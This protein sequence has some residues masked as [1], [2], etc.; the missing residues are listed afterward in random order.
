MPEQTMKI[1]YIGRKA[2]LNVCFPWMKKPV[3]MVP[4]N[5]ED[6]AIDDGLRL[7]NDFPETFQE[8]KE[9]PLEAF[10]RS[11]NQQT[12]DS[13][14][15]QIDVNEINF[16]EKDGQFL[17]PFCKKTYVASDQGKIWLIKHLEKEHTAVWADALAKA[18]AERA[19]AFSANGQEG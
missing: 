8:W 17:C 19:D 1:M 3:M 7:I 13:N 18:K 10:I 9:D 16:E 5:A 14:K 4:K 2:G 12:I 11:K 6:I 15:D